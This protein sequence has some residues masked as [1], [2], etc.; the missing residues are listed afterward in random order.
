MHCKA[1]CVWCSAVQTSPPPHLVH[2]AQRLVQ[3]ASEVAGDRLD[4]HRNT[5]T[6]NLG[7]YGR[8]IDNGATVIIGS[9]RNGSR[10]DNIFK[11]HKGVTLGVV[12]E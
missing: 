4:L 2:R 10:L 5:A 3:A 1:L 7:D 8:L 11:I 6:D 9:D 12:Q